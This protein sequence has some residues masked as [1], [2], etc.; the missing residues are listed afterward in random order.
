MS[1]SISAG[2]AALAVASLAACTEAPLA[3]ATETSGPALSMA[4]IAGS[5]DA[6]Q[7]VEGE[8]L[9]KFKDGVNAE[10]KAKGNGLG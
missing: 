7:V 4:R 9:V 10:T 2:I 6:E 5:Q 1:R 8:V 3:P